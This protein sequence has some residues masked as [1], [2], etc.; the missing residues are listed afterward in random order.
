MP[1]FDEHLI[2]NDKDYG[3]IFGDGHDIYIYDESNETNSS[4]YFPYTYNREGENKL[5]M[6]KDTYCMFSGGSNFK[7]EEYE[8]F[9]IWFSPWYCIA[10]FN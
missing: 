10:S 5:A 1:Q 9:Q 3:P 7:V 4:A 2:F 6:N 8:V